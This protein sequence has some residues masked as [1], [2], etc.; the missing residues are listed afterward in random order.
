M[1]WNDVFSDPKTSTPNAAVKGTTIQNW[2]KGTLEA[3]GEAG[4]SSLDSTYREMYLNQECCRVQPPTGPHDKFSFCY[5]RDHTAGVDTKLIPL[6][7]G[8]E[9]NLES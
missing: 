5:Y 2:G 9:V 6:V 7:N 8:G 1:G 3:F 4:F